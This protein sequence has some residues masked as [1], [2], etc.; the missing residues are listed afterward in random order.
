MWQEQDLDLSDDVEVEESK[1][2]VP[3]MK[4]S[5]SPRNN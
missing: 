2:I 1:D 3:Q 5:A 4:I